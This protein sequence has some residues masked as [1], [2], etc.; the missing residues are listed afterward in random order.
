MSCVCNIE[1]DVVIIENAYALSGNRATS[2]HRHSCCTPMSWPLYI[3]HALRFFVDTH[4]L[5]PTLV[6]VCVLLIELKF[7]IKPHVVVVAHIRIHMLIEELC[8]LWRM[9]R[10][11]LPAM[12]QGIMQHIGIPCHSYNLSACLDIIVVVVAVAAAA[13]VVVIIRQ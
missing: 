1:N 12:T 4:R 6:Y 9:E 8:F 5:L 11:P 13:A 7:E 10:T 2:H 3:L